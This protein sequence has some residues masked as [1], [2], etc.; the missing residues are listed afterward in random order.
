[1]FS[2]VR[3]ENNQSVLPFTY[4]KNNESCDH[5]LQH[6]QKIF[7]L[8]VLFSQPFGLLCSGLVPV[9]YISQGY[10]IRSIYRPGNEPTPLFLPGE[11]HRQRNLAGYSPQSHKE[12]DM[13]QHSTVLTEGNS[14]DKATVD[15]DGGCDILKREK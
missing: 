9:L 8:L 6:F 1:M 7:S 4:L 11:S 15:C 12:S 5:I 13:T 10:E 3:L 2:L 14:Q